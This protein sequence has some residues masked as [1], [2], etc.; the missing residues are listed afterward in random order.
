MNTGTVLT[1]FATIFVLA[2]LPSSS[3]MI[4]AARSVA[5][6]FLHGVMATLGIVAGDILFILLAV[7]GLA[8]LTETLGNLFVV[9]KLSGVAT[10]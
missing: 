10:C 1:L 8:M 6:G 7:P 5:S 9:V 3:A 4:V 2:L